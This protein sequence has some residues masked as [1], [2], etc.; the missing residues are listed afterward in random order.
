M[1]AKIINY[2]ACA[3]SAKGYVS[4]FEDNINDLERL[5]ILKGGPATGKSTLMKKLG[6]EWYIR[7]FDVEYIHCPSDN[8]S[9]DGIILPSL[10]IGIVDGTAPHVIE[11]RAPGALDEYVNMGV[12]W[13]CKKLSQD[14]DKILSI[15]NEISS[16]YENAY[17]L[18]AEGLKIHDEWEKVYI[19][20]IDFN[21]MNELTQETICNI[22][23]NKIADKQSKVKNRFF[24]GATPKGSVDFV[25]DLTD[26]MSKRYFIKGRPGSGKSTM[27]RKI[28]ESAQDRGFDVEIYHCGFDPDSLDM[29]IVRELSVAIFDSTAPHEYFPSKST[30]TIID[31]YEHA[32]KPGTDEEYK[33]LLEDITSGYKMKIR[34]GTRYLAN[35]KEL[36]DDLEN[37]YIDAID[38]E[39]V[40]KIQKDLK[41]KIDDYFFSMV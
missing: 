30:D 16:C 40:D 35:A 11:P 32:I 9:I 21:K 34:E 10:G 18:F 26:D 24:G 27:L 14:R 4:Y 5:Y 31:V 7:G 39:I 19:S 6:K 20:N 38:Y 13:D 22:F 28:A 3:N 12:S 41:H 25:I 15:K 8:I 17:K 29:I 36:N 23:G 33:G 2:Y 1:S 37:I